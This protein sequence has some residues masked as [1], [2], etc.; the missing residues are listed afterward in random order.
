MTDQTRHQSGARHTDL[1]AL[2]TAPA[3]ATF[4]GGQTPVVRM[5]RSGVRSGRGEGGWICFSSD[6][7]TGAGGS[8]MRSESLAIAAVNATILALVLTGA[9]A[10]VA[11]LFQNLHQMTV[12]VLEEAHKING[13]R[14]L[15]GGGAYGKYAKYDPHDADQRTQLGR[16][17]DHYISRW[18]N[19]WEDTA[20]SHEDFLRAVEALC[21]SYPFPAGWSNVDEQWKLYDEPVPVTFRNIKDVHD[22]RVAIEQLLHRPTRAISVKADWVAEVTARYVRYHPAG[23]AFD[24]TTTTP[25]P[26]AT[27]IV[28][29]FARFAPAAYRLAAEVRG[30]EEALQRYRKQLPSSRKVIPLLIFGA[31]LFAM[32]VVYPLVYPNRS[33]FF[34]TWIPG[35]SY[36]VA[37]LGVIIRVA[38]AYREAG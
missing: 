22:W 15:S 4:Q 26:I 19:G 11:F 21:S 9:T 28:E 25:T 14:W 31:L 35:I 23:Q 2:R 30:K 16:H 29:N 1:S 32:G 7:S 37:L 6:P 10:Y 8:P 18:P 24:P 33:Y 13:F 38:L 17:I 5:R 34:T 36:L 12:D 27:R 3:E 20:G